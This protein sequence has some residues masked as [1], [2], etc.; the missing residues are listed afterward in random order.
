MGA[1]TAF[2]S[3]AY[4]EGTWTPVLTFATPG[5]LAVAYTTQVGTYTRIGNLVTV[6]C[7][8]LL[9]SFVH[10][11]ASG[12]LQITGLPFTSKTVAGSGYGAQGAMRFEGITKAS[13]T[14]FSAQ[15]GS[16]AALATIIACRPDAGAGAAPVTAADMP[17][18]GTVRVIFTLT[19]QI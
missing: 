10:G 17:T 3:P 19:Y 8:L 6:N 11:T 7:S 12:N 9:S 15:I 18:G 14:Q 13:Y 1:A 16:A 2:P 5:D 4:S